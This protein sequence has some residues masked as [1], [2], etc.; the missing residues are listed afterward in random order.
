M[1]FASKHMHAGG[2]IVNLS[3]ISGRSGRPDQAHYAAAKA[4][5]ISLTQSAALALAGQNITVNAVCPGV[6]ET[7]MTM[8]IHQARAGT[9]GI[10]PEESLARM[11]A[12]IP[13]GRLEKTDDVAGAVAFLC[14]PDAAYITGQSLNVCGGM[15]MN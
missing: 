1:Q 12:R 2:R 6:V 3:S 11:V 15:E 9:L 10:T 4:G 8:G 7:P 14:S 13:L 5:V